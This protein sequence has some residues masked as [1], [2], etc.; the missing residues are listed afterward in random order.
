MHWQVVLHRR[1][2]RELDELPDH[3]REETLS[4]IDGFEEGVFPPD[5]LLLHGEP[6]TYRAYFGKN[7]RVVWQ[8]YPHSR[9]IVVS[10][11]RPRATAYKGFRRAQD[12]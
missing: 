6:K 7:F 3:L 11:L 5:V 8:A 1:A 4:I 12:R 10:R 9:R 2:Q